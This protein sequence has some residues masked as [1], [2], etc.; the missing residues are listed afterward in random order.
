M[1]L[2]CDPDWAVA[3]REKY[4][5]VAPGYHT[6][7]RHWNTVTLDGSIPPDELV[8]LAEHS[9]ARVLDGLARRDRERLQHAWDENQ[10]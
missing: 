8:D 5:A 6:N 10:A 4:A 3:L 2:K 9:Y 7:K 1:T